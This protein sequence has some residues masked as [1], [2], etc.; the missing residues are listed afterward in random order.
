[1]RFYTLALAS[2][3]ALTSA[4]AALAQTPAPTPAATSLA[5]SLSGEARQAYDAGRLLFADGD[6][7]GAIAKFRR[8]H[9]LSRDPRLLW[10]MAVCEKE[11]RHYASAARLVTRYL[12]EGS[13]KISAES[14]QSAEA[15]KEAL[16]SFYSELTLNGVP[17]G[18]LVSV[19]GVS[20]GTAPFTEPV[21]V[22]LGRRRVR[23][24]QDGFEPFERQLDVP[25]AV[26]VS[27][28]VSLTRIQ[29][30]GTVSITSSEAN[31]VI[32]V[33]GK[34]VGHGQWQGSLA[35]GDHVVRVTAAG[36]KPYE[37][38]VLL[39]A[40]GSKSLSVALQDESKGGAWWP[41]V[42]GGVAVLAGAGVGGYFLLKPDEKAGNAPAGKL[43]TIYLPLFGR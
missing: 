8:A 16:R 6:A 17:A 39:T 32:S 9:E 22:D 1:M 43:G 3:L 13:S 10:N 27:L 24:E 36:K 25:G 18:A 37:A 4:R 2:C 15:T 26:P 12:A 33:D 7:A 34:V 21:P 42:A 31:S 40:K 28:E 14:R 5:D 23:V 11:L 30:T 19:D 38:H 20:V 35:A 41:W 29:N